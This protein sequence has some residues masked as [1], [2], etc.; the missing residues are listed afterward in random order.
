[1]IIDPGAQAELKVRQVLN[2]HGL[3]PEGIICSHGHFDHVAD[4]ASLAN[5]FAVPVWLHPDDRPML[6]EPVLGFGPGSEPI[7]EQLAGTTV[8]PAPH[9]LRELADGGR[10]S[11]AGVDFEVIHAPGHTPG[12]VVLRTHTADQTLLFSGDVLFAG[13]I[14]RVDLP[15]G[16]MA[17][18]NESLRKLRALIDAGTGILP[19]HGPTTTMAREL[20]T[21][22]YLSKEALA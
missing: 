19:G 5:D 2:E 21:N 7:I 14:G 13:S 16:S 9:D 20:A 17:Q 15:G 4:A 18:M 22:P 8:L 12:C 1:M 11:L 10:L 3:H 6:T